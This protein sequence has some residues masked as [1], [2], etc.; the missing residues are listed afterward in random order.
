MKISKQVKGKLI[1]F[2]LCM[3]ML[4]LT[5]PAFAQQK[6]TV[7]AMMIGFQMQ[8]WIDPVTGTTFNGF[9]KMVEKFNAERPN[10]ELKFTS[11]PWG[12]LI[13]PYAKTLS[14]LLGG[15]ADVIQTRIVYIQTGQFEPLDEYIEKD[16]YD[17]GK[18]IAHSAKVT[19]QKVAGDKEAHQYMLPIYAD[20]R[21]I[22]YDKKIF[23]DYGVAYLSHKPTMDE[24]RE[25]GIKLTGADPVTG[26]KTYGLWFEGNYSAWAFLTYVRAFGGIPILENGS[27]PN[28]TSDASLKA[29]RWLYELREKEV[30]PAKCAAISGDPPGW[31]SKDNKHAIRLDHNLAITFLAKERGLVERFGVS[32]NVLNKWGYAGLLGA[33]DVPAG[34]AKLSENK[35]A[36]WEVLKWLLSEEVQRFRFDNNRVFPVL[37]KEISQ[38]LKEDNL[39]YADVIGEQIKLGDPLIGNYSKV[40]TEGRMVI[41]STISKLLALDITPEEAAEVIQQEIMTKV[42]L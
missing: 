41:R 19:R 18:L 3:V 13:G 7:K 23:D 42:I 28:F 33:S 15:T 35:D 30:I 36:A 22:A 9:S 8:D 25:K 37:E 17:L 39:P 5:S 29:L 31:L 27:R 2:I 12:A 16:N 21:L 32:L 26:E 40:I 10:I 24:L 14:A 38:W 34:I 1:I 4:G 11:I 6:T 20:A